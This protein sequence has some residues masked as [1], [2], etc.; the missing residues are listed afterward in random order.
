MKMKIKYLKALV[1]LALAL[2]LCI[3][4]LSSCAEEV[5]DPVM[6]HGENAISLEI[7]E[8]LLSRT[9]ATLA[10]RGYD[11]SA[12]SEFWGKEYGTSGLTNEQYYS[13]VAAE[14]CK[15]YLAA[16]AVFDEEGM[17][18]SDAKLAAIDEEIGFYIEYDGK[19]DEAKLD[20]ILAKYGTSTEGLRK[21]YELEAKY[22]AVI[23]A[24]YGSGASQ[25]A[26]NVKDEYYKENYHRFKQILIAN[27]YYEYVVD[28]EGDTVYFDPENGKPIYDTSGEYHYDDKGNRI[29]DDYGVAIRYDKD[30]NILYDTKKGKPAPTKDENG[31]AIEHKYTDEEMAE[32]VAKIEGIIA[33]ANGGNYAAFEKEM[34]DWVVYAGADEYCP[35]GYYFSDIEAGAYDENMIKLLTALKG[36]N[37]GEVRAVEGENGYH[38]IMKYELDAGKYENSGYAEW[39]LEFDASLINKL[40]ADKC[41]KYYDGI[42]I[43]QENIDKATSIRNIGVNYDY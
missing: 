25:I 29:V 11:V 42:T 22:N 24:L 30:G 19:G 31:K 9:K 38:V 6:E 7:Y 36:M 2:V 32:R 41:A 15:K 40:F 27:Y 18:L 1:C 33:A 35:D 26:G 12:N 8:F 13:K 4:P 43:N 39:F 17:T 34:P 23:T 16:L 28:T 14:T 20:A 5:K 37:V 21:M 3:I 10:R